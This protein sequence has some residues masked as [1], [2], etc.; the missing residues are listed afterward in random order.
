MEA[1]KPQTAQAILRKKNGAEGIRLP[2]FRLHKSTI[3]KTE[4]Y[5][6]KK[7][8]RSMEQDRKSRNKPMHLWSINL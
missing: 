4:W 7:K 5:W 2:D 8:Y 6:Q 3:I 1:Q